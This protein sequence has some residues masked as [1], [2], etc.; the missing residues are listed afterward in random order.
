M[1]PRGPTHRSCSRSLGPASHGGAMRRPQWTGRPAPPPP[2][3]A[4]ALAA[5]RSGVGAAAVEKQSRDGGDGRQEGGKEGEKEGGRSGKGGEGRGHC[6]RGAGG[7][8]PRGDSG[9]PGRPPACPPLCTEGRIAQPDLPLRRARQTRPAPARAG[10][11]RKWGRGALR[12][13]GPPPSP[14]SSGGPL[15]PG[16]AARPNQPAQ[17]D[18]RAPD[19]EPLGSTLLE[20][21][22][23]GPCPPPWSVV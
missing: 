13:S 10:P 3:G 12:G 9:H 15:S 2:V 16:Q 22:G 1:A 4:P 18:P 5:T 19:P 21:E 23:A 6:G 14:G 17:P 11:L 8:D 7:T 20:V